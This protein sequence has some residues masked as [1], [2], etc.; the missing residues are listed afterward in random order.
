M[1][2]KVVNWNLDNIWKIP[3]L[4][5]SPL[6]R[7]P[8]MAPHCP[9]NMVQIL[10]LLYNPFQKPVL[11]VRN[12]GNYPCLINYPSL[13]PLI[14]WSCSAL[15]TSYSPHAVALFYLCYTLWRRILDPFLLL[16]SCSQ[17]SLM[18]LVNYPF[19]LFFSKGNF[20][21]IHPNSLNRS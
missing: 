13:L 8:S 18:A 7:K 14:H 15:G 10:I 19:F 1:H 4:A 21:A 12:H 6:S 16:H 3:I 9:H 20:L 5:V 2:V 17:L 11:A